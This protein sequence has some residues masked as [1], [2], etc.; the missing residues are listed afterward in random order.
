L[1]CRGCREHV[2]KDEKAYMA[3]FEECCEIP[4]F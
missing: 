1:C 3:G 2:L 4:S